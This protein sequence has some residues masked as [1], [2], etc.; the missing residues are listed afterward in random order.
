M[1]KCK[2]KTMNRQQR[3]AAE[4]QLRKGQPIALDDVLS[5]ALAL[6]QEGRLSDAEGIALIQRALEV[7]PTYT[8]AHNNLGNVYKETGDLDKAAECYRKVIKLTP[9]HAPVLSNLGIVLRN[10]GEN[11]AAVLALLRATELAPTI[12][13]FFRIW[14]M[15][16]G[17]KGA[18]NSRP[19][20]SADPSLCNPIRP[21][22]TKIY[23]ESIMWSGSLT[24]PP[25]FYGNGWNSIRKTL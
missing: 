3:R 17:S 15:L 4:K 24:R 19:R 12:T 6:H 22:P 23:G 8:D 10:Q 18:L 5:C 7:L 25:R 20:H 1:D 21:M 14:A 16:T 2:G 13:I 9:D 11:E